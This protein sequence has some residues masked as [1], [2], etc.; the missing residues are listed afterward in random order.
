MDSLLAKLRV[1]LQ[2]DSAAFEQGTNRARRQ[3]EEFGSSAEQLGFKI[4]SMIRTMIGAGAAL[5]ASDLAMQIKDVVQQSLEYADGIAKAAQISNA[6]AAEFQRAA[7]AAGTLGISS[8]KLSDI[9]K[10][11]NDKIGEFLATGG[12]EMKDFFTQIAPKVG[13]TAEAFRGLSGPEALQLYVKTLERAGVS[14]QQATFYMEALA[15]DATALLPLLRNNGAEMDRLG[16]AAASMG[17]V[18]DDAMIRKAQQA[19]Q[20]MGELG[21][22]LQARLAVFVVDNSDKILDLTNGMMNL[23]DRVFSLIGRLR[24][25]MDLPVIKWF[26]N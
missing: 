5:A 24:N 14:Q 25:L 2:L 19:K 22:V 8:E 17:I 9:Y 13:V 16:E 11:V 21:T 10:D 23:T 1:A 26:R 20:Q 7:Y 6:T 4:G 3:T 15:N 12:G 18:M